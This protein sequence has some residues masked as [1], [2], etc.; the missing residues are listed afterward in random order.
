MV[1]YIGTEYYV[2]FIVYGVN[3]NMQFRTFD[4]VN[5]QS[6]K[7]GKQLHRPPTADARDYI[8]IDMLL[9]RCT[10]GATFRLHS[11]TLL[12]FMSARHGCVYLLLDML[13]DATHAI[14]RSRET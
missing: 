9:H 6:L 10:V 1:L 3:G 8:D 13:N 12:S 4:K 2:K 5:V 11:A 14:A 7:Y